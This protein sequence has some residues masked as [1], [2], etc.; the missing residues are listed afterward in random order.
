MTKTQE[1]LLPSK[2]GPKN[3]KASGIYACK[4]RQTGKPAVSLLCSMPV[5]LVASA[6][7]RLLPSLTEASRLRRL[8]PGARRVVGAPLLGRGGVQPRP[9]R[10]L[11]DVYLPMY[12]FVFSF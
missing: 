2:D 3:N 10:V 11:A 9:V 4:N 8:I 1:Y 5:L 6:E 12:A 7:D